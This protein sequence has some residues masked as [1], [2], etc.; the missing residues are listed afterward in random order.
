MIHLIDLRDDQERVDWER[1]NRNCR[2][3]DPGPLTA[4]KHR[5]E[6]LTLGAPRLANVNDAHP[7]HL[8]LVRVVERLDSGVLDR[9]GELNDR[10]ERLG[11]GTNKG[12]K[13]HACS[14]AE[15]QLLSRSSW[16]A[17]VKVRIKRSKGRTDGVP[18]PHVEV[19]VDCVCGTAMHGT[20][21]VLVV[22]LEEPSKR[23]LTSRVK[24]CN[25]KQWTTHS[26]ADRAD[27]A[28]TAPAPDRDEREVERSEFEADFVERWAD[29]LG[30]AAMTAIASVAT[31]VDRRGGSRDGNDQPADLP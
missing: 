22:Q 20:R 3:F 23:E 24:T 25:Q 17:G 27:K 8:V 21:D 29:W 28:E 13:V 12:T 16:W 14:K 15:C 19:N 1:A 10:L 5:R 7:A 18:A 31:I 2:Q 26:E 9:L 6:W 4:S 30:A 11:L